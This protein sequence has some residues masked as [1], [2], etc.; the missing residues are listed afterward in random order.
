ML[1]KLSFLVSMPFMAVLVISL[2][3]VLALAT[4]V[5]SAYGTQTA[6]AVIY[7][8]HWFELLMLLI[9]INLVGVMVKQKFFRRKKIVVLLFHLAFILI[10]L[11]ASVTRFI[12][13]EGNM[14][15]RENSA[16]DVMLSNN[17]YI[18]VLLEA[19]GERS[20]H[21]REVMLTELT[22]KDY[23][24]STRV[25]GEKV[26]IRSTEYLSSAIEQYISS[27]GGEP[28]MQLMLVS[29]R[30]TTIG[31]PSGSTQEVN[32]MTIGFNRADTS[33]MV[34]F[35]SR[36][37]MI[38]MTAPF[39]VSV[40][41]MGGAGGE[42]YAPGQEVPVRENTLY[43]MANMRLA[44]QSYM[45]SARKQIVRAPAGQRG[46]HLGAVRLE[47]S[48]RGMTG[49]LY[50]PG[51]ARLAGQPV[52]GSMG[53]LNY[54]VTY[55]SREIKVP[56]SLFLKNFEVERYPGSNSPSSFASDVVLLDQEMGIQEERRIFMNNVLKHRGY[57]F[58]QASYDNDEQGTILSVNRD[59]AGTLITYLGYLVLIAGMVVALF[60]PGTRFSMI[61]RKSAPAAKVL[62]MVLLLLGGSL[63]LFSQEVP[64]RDVAQD[65]G[66]LWVQDKGGRFEPM[67]TLSNEVV[68]KI[69]KH[70]HY[71]SYSADQVL[72]GMILYPD[73]WQNKELFEIKHPELHRLTGYRGE[74]VSFKDMMDST[75]SYLLSNLVN[76]A[77]AKQVPMQT[78]LDRELIKLDD[79]L[80]AFYLV[81]SGGLIRI[82]PDEGAENHRWASLS[83]AMMGQMTQKEDT[84]S[85][86]F[87]RYLSA[88]QQGDYTAAGF[89]VDQLGESQLSSEILPPESKKKMELIYNRIN[90]FP[91]LAR[92]YAL[93]GVIMMVLAFLLVFRPR[94][95]YKFLFKVGVIHLSVALVAHTVA[96]GLRWYIS[97]HAPMSNGYESM[98]FVAWVTL[99]AGLI[100]VKRSGYALALT[101]ILAALSL[102][103]AGMSNMNPEITNLVPVL[104]SVWLTI[105]VAVIMAGYGF[106]G[107][108]SIMGLLNV[109][110]YASLSP[111]NKTRLEEVIQQVTHVNHLTLI[112]GLYFMTAGVFL[113]GVWANE[114]WGRYW[115][116]DPKE[117]WALITVLVYAFV[118]H[119]HR[120]PGL[121]GSFAFNLASFISYS[122]V[123]MT[124][125]GVNY[126]L[127]GMHSY[128]SGSSFTIPLWT[129][130]ILLML[131]GL[132]V[133]AFRK[134]QKL[135]PEKSPDEARD[136]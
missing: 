111:S 124:Y 4:F 62:V 52:S 13:Y 127:G 32:G 35:Y 43:A 81:Q 3:V 68:R 91:L 12:S 129:Y 50:V 33:A 7:G 57:R 79:R 94:K 74:M 134:Q 31:I 114:S 36:G 98:I 65:F 41:Q 61:A 126:F 96:L 20:E 110:L 82:F 88:L 90:I 103:V 119:M 101:A 18:N 71:Q 10:L 30:Q 80:N 128:A 21:A 109:A 69:T 66:Y 73:V 14:H 53:D 9:G 125:F 123:M 97:G 84:M 106:L 116:W 29:D 38:W 59:R 48:Y 102:L 40:M 121:R 89:Y 77:Y 104:K 34:N 108:A 51:L 85:N 22:P 37:D 78:E 136:Q 49:E 83:E 24:M 55:G 1:K 112:V 56:F 87:F 113:G 39:A 11:G 93:F 25:G 16:S 100:F 122:S 117:T 28:Y 133:F 45:P 19:R 26:T 6:W 72:L 70:S 75:G 67:N 15:I 42:E 63:S 118:T 120:I 17:A 107:L 27:P 47:I 58:Y 44:L 105:H 130:L 86:V 60:V 5:E 135:L 95:L 131:V 132:S 64:P 92:F 99:L 8:T 76:E 2:I 54:T 23:R 115:G 46:S